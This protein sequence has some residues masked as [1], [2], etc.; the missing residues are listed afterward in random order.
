MVEASKN[1]RRLQRNDV[2]QPSHSEKNARCGHTR[3]KKKREAKH[4]VEICVYNRYDK[5]EG[6]RGQHNQEGNMEE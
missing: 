2:V 3:E 4:K 1:I 6:D 5:G